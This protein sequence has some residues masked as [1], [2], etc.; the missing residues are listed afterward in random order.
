MNRNKKKKEAEKVVFTLPRR[1]PDVRVPVIPLEDQTP[2]IGPIYELIENVL[3]KG[4]DKYVYKRRLKS[5]PPLGFPDK[6][7]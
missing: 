4:T 3:S 6:D 5:N 7:D 1:K 2:V